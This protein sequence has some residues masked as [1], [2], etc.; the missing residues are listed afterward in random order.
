MVVRVL[1]TVVS[2]EHTA[3]FFQAEEYVKQ[4]AR[5][6]SVYTLPLKMAAP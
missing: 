6:F 2:D 3:S 5:R 1:N 4:A